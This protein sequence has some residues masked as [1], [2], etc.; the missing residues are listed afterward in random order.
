MP[1]N[2]YPPNREIQPTSLCFKCATTEV[3]PNLGKAAQGTN[4][5]SAL[6]AAADSGMPGKAQ[7]AC[8]LQAVNF[9]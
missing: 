1:T 6:V 4:G 5:F 7:P 2:G 3:H 8:H 9:L